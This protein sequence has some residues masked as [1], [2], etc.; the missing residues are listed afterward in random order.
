MP[1]EKPSA[2]VQMHTR[3]VCRRRRG[4]GA[5][6]RPGAST[7]RCLRGP[8]SATFCASRGR[9]PTEGAAWLGVSWVLALFASTLAGCARLIRNAESPSI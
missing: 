9:R 5:G 1:P 8:W 6:A 4:E 7:M 2:E 3:A